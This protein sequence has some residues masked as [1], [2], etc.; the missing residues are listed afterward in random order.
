MK[1]YTIKG[2]L[3]EI[4]LDNDKVVK[5]GKTYIDRCIDKLGID[6]EDALLTWLEDEGH[7]ENLDQVELCNQ[8]K[9]NKSNKIIGA[10]VEKAKAKT[11]KERTQKPQPEKEYI[12]GVIAELLEDITGINNLTIENKAKII[13]FTYKNSEYKLDLTQKRKPKA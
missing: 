8:A 12:I 1:N 11:Q 13:T 5:V 6:M 3:I 10:K 9:E 7:L 2:S 4:V